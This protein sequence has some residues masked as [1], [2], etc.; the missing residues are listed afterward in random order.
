MLIS[1][2]SLKSIQGVFVEDNQATIRI[3]ESGKSPSL[4]RTDKTQRVNL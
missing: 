1:M 2:L 3:L 4:R